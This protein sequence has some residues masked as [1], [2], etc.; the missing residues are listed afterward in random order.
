[1]SET[2][3]PAI[4]LQVNGTHRRPPR[5]KGSCANAQLAPSLR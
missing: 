3:I 4:L 5:M 2:V 1:V